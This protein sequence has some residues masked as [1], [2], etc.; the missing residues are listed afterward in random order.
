VVVAWG[1]G[2]QHAAGKQEMVWVS[3]G[4]G[5][6]LQ[7]EKLT[8]RNSNTKWVS[9]LAENLA[10][11][12]HASNEDACLLPRC[13]SRLLLQVRR[14]PTP[15]SYEYISSTLSCLIQVCRGMPRGA[16]RCQAGCDKG[17]THPDSE[18]A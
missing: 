18:Y 5:T 1:K 7:K 17:R 13:L 4:E 16:L 11:E 9:A 15:N 3:V 2:P 14:L 6:A 8:A 12:G 10:A